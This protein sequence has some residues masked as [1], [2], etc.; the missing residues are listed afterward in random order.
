[1]GRADPDGD[2]DPNDNYERWINACPIKPI[3]FTGTV[4]TCDI[5]ATCAQRTAAGCSGCASGG[6]VDASSCMATWLTENQ[7][8]TAELE[9]KGFPH[10][11]F[12]FRGGG[13]TPN[14][15]GGY[16]LADQLRWVFKDITCF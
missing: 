6:Q 11:L 5:Y 9:A 8:V 15:W 1:M 10:Q 12:I 13:H 7:E 14:V 2:G 4:G 3:R 16:A